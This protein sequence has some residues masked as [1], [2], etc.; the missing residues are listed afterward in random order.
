MI[1][2][3]NSIRNGHLNTLF[4]DCW[5]L[6][7]LIRFFISATKS[8]FDSVSLISTRGEVNLKDLL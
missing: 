3:F 8:V 1:S 2:L 5:V 4:S 6:E 7:A